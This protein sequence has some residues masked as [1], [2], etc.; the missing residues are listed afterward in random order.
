MTERADGGSA[1]RAGPGKGEEAALRRRAARARAAGRAWLR[2]LVA[3]WPFVLGAACVAAGLAAI[4]LGYLG[5]SGTLVVGLQVPYLM[6]GGLL[7]LA[8]V[9]LGSALLVAHAV[10]RQAK[11]MRRMLEEVRGRAATVSPGPPAPSGNSVVVVAEGGRTFHRPDCLIVAGKDVRRLEPAG[12]AGKGL[13][14]CRI[15]DPEPATA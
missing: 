5:A 15:C 14:P 10:G 3:F 11:L 9:T 4:V 7:G 6:S 8:L 1:G 2:F 12:A 13:L